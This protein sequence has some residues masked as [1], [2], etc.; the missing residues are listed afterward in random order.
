MLPGLSLRFCD[1]QMVGPVFSTN[2]M[3]G[4]IHP[5]LYQRFSLVLVCGDIILANFGPLGTI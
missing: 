5:I 4:W 1:I 2:N 3:K